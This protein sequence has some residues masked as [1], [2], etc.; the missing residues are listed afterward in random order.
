MAETLTAN[1]TWTKPD[2]GACANTWGATLNADLDKIDAQVFANQTAINAGQVPIGS[3]SMFGGATPPANWLICDGSSLSTAAPYDKLFAVLQYAYGGSGANFNLPNLQGVFPLG[4]GPS[5]ALGSTGGA[6]TVTLDVADLPSHG[7]PD[8]RCRHND[9]PSHAHGF[10]S[11]AYARHDGPHAYG[12][13]RFSAAARICTAD[14]VGRQR[15]QQAARPRRSIPRNVGAA[16]PACGL[17]SIQPT[18][19]TSISGNATGASA[20]VCAQQS[21]RPTSPSIFIIRYAMSTP[22]P[23]DPNPARRRRDADEENAVHQLVRS[24]FRALARGPA[25]ADGRA[26]AVHQRRSAASSSIGSPRAA[27]RS[28]AGMASMASTTSPISARRTSTSTRAGR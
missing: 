19:G 22:V 12:I 15:N 14:L 27:R 3:I 8:H 21:C 26:G 7:A 17:R 23:A 6:A 1:F 20:A 4:A 24:Q 9:T 28:T 16:E 13:I 2:P 25:H 11:C 10:Q 18:S 5:N